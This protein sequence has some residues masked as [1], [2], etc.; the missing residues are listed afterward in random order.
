MFAS[1]LIQ[2]R[3][4]LTA[5]LLGAT[6]FGSAPLSAETAGD[7]VLREKKLSIGIHNRPPWG[8]RGSDGQATGFHPDLVRA[9]FAPLGVTEIAFTISDFGALIPGLIANRFDMVASG[10]G[11][12]PERCKVVAF[13]DPDMSIGDALLV[14]AG[15]PLGVHSYK[16]IAAN[17]KVRLGA[18]RGSANGKNATLAGVPESQMM[19]FQN[20]EASM[21]A[22]MAGRVDVLT[23]SSPTVVGFLQ[24]P[25]IT[26]VERV[27]PFT[28]Y[29]KPN[30]RESALS[31][32]IAFR[33]AD[34]DLRDLYNKRLAEMK[35]DG[36]LA[37]IM[38][39]Y[40]FGDAEKA[41]ELT[42][43]QICAGED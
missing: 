40:G 43:Q 17:P 12:T 4:F 24:D 36:S 26:G 31:S 6:M 2:R 42:A 38:K 18:S 14:K 10:L 3:G 22:L 30:G 15:N 13:S 11:I 27:K 23:F 39:K 1:R 5:L 37:A 19:L 41:P 33:P 7:R 8:I 29:I 9:A 16:D 32:A 25:N 34:A 21:S 28:G 20:T 35:A